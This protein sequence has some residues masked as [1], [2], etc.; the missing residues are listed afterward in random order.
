[1][2]PQRYN[3]MSKK[4]SQKTT[5]KKPQAKTAKPRA[6]AK[7]R[8]GATRARAAAPATTGQAHA[9]R[10]PAAGSEARLPPVGTVIQKRDRYG[11]VRCECTVDEAGICYK[12]KLYGS[13]SGAAMAAASD[14]GL[15][16]K[17]QNG[18]TFWGLTKPTRTLD[19]PEAALKKACA[20]FRY[21]ATAAAKGA[22]DENRAKIR[23]ALQ[24][25]GQVVENLLGQVA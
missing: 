5:S 9:T 6:A 10:R 17:T 3:I 18:F 1:M 25:H 20:R 12:G 11:T 15:T 8:A 7:Q 4:Q 23:A 16:N 2:I 19:D 14:L 13:L 24:Q 22:T 21:L